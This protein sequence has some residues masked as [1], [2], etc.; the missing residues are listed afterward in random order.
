V[1]SP[2][3]QSSTPWKP[4][5]TPTSVPTPP[6]QDNGHNGHARPAGRHHTAPPRPPHGGG[7]PQPKSAG[8]V[9]LDP[10]GD[11]HDVNNPYRSSPTGNGHHDK[12]QPG[13]QWPSEQS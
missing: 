3:P 10:K 5:P 4:S 7:H 9:R 12:W 2:S 11:G 6:S 1:V 13:G 8:D